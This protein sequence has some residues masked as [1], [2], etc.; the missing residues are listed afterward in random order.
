MRGYPITGDFT[1]DMAKKTVDDFNKFGK[2]LKD[3]YGLTFCYHNHGYE[4][5]PVP[6]EVASEVKGGSGKDAVRLHRAENR[7]EVREL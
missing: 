1:L 3:D 4:F 7:P 2:T 6:A 5:Q